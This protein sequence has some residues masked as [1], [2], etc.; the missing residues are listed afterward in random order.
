VKTAISG[1]NLGPYRQQ[2]TGNAK[3][4]SW[5]KGPRPQKKAGKNKPWM[6]GEN[7]GLF[8]KTNRPT[9][10]IGVNA[11]RKK[12]GNSSREFLVVLPVGGL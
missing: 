12:K 6:A 3:S 9:E 4:R 11:N 1:T 2:W 5:E 10:F 7:L 8:R